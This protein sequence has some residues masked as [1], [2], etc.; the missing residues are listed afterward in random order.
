MRIKKRT[1]KILLVV[2]LMFAAGFA[3]LKIGSGGRT[4][5][6]NIALKTYYTAA[7]GQNAEIIELRKQGREHE[8]TISVGGQP[9]KKSFDEKAIVDIERWIYYYGLF[10][11]CMDDKNIR[12]FVANNKDSYLQLA[13]LPLL[14]NDAQK[15]LIN[16]DAEQN[17]CRE[18][19]ISVTPSILYNGNVYPGVK[20]TKSFMA[21]TDCIPAHYA[22][23]V[24]N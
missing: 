22:V 21:L 17:K 2:L 6:T 11:K 5:K 7:T 19:G 3:I 1:L 20:V 15:Y 9:I 18:K 14:G 12:I 13:M 16:C 8:A 24:P 23:V 4:E 10:K